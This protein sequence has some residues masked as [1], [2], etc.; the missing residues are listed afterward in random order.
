MSAS[1]SAILAGLHFQLPPTGVA[2]DAEHVV[3]C[4]ISKRAADD[5]K[6]ST[7]VVA[8][9]AIAVSKPLGQQGG[10]LAVPPQ[11]LTTRQAWEQT[12]WQSHYDLLPDDCRVFL[13]EISSSG[14][15]R[16]PLDYAR[17]KSFVTR[18]LNLRAFGIGRGD[19]L[20]VVIP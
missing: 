7:G 16:R 5:A 18:D 1:R 19:R 9:P 8:P 11:Q 3:S 17:L 15:R 10:A 6:K 4:C 13:R 14:R 20:C 2:E 12:G